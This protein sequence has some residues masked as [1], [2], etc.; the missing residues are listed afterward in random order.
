[1][2]INEGDKLVIKKNLAG[3]FDEG[4]IVEVTSVK[5]NNITFECINNDEGLIR[6]GTMNFATCMEHF[7]K[8]EEKKAPAISTGRIEW[9]IEN[10]DIKIDTVFDKCVVVSC[11]LPNGYVIVESYVF[12]NSEEYNEDIGIE[13]CIGKIADKLW[14][15]EAYRI[16]DKMHGE[17]DCDYCD[18]SCCDCDECCEECEDECDEWDEDI[19]VDCDNCEDYDCPNNPNR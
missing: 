8:V 15:L 3:F 2:H 6:T 14:E 12:T 19:D 16:H 17:N 5:D 13:I 18:G 9:L 10:S 1:M 11:R 4:E 7:D